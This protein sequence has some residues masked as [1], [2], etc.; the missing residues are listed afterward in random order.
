MYLETMRVICLGALVVACGS[1]PHEFADRAID[2]AKGSA[3]GEA[4]AS[5][6]GTSGAPLTS[7]GSSAVE[8]APAG[9]TGGGAAGTTSSG[10][11]GAAGGMSANAGTT[12]TGGASAGSGGTSTEP[13][14]G[15]SGEPPSTCGEGWTSY[16]VEP[17]HCLAAGVSSWR[18]ATLHPD[19]RYVF[20]S[21]DGELC[22]PMQTGWV[23]VRPGKDGEPIVISVRIADDAPGEV[24][25]LQNW[26]GH[27][28][29]VAC[30]NL[31]IGVSY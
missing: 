28:G 15:A 7:G 16:T 11:G 19:R 23:S 12:S 6:V 25:V 14:G 22:D 1:A 5:P 18:D 3:A 17:G 20:S 29:D 10:G 9:G 13:T 31:P 8:P 27:A 2:E 4:P 26:E 24:K 21:V 30:G